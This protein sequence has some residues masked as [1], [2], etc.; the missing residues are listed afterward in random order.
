MSGWSWRAKFN[1][2]LTWRAEI[3]GLALG[4]FCMLRQK[5]KCKVRKRERERERERERVTIVV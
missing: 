5:A 1:P 3:L 4:R 2:V